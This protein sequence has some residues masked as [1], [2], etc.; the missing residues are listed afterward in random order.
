M[1][2]KHK[3]NNVRSGKLKLKARVRPAFGSN[4]ISKTEADSAH[5][6][7][8]HMGGRT[9]ETPAGRRAQVALNRRKSE[10]KIRAG[11]GVKSLATGK[12]IGKA[13]SGK[14]KVSSAVKKAVR[15]K[16]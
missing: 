16:K 9:A 6:A 13:S 7:V 1:P 2:L 14:L 12:T 3:G 8:G 15:K 11:Q 10:V 4:K 5:A